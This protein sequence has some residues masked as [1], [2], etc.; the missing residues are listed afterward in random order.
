MKIGEKIAE[1]RREKGVTQAELA[2]QLHF[3][4]QAV[5]NWERGVTEPDAHTLPVLA[6]YFG[7]TTDELLG[8]PPVRDAPPARS[9]APAPKKYAAPPQKHR[10]EVRETVRATKALHIL[11]WVYAGLTA[12]DLLLSFSKNAAVVLLGGICGIAAAAANL[13]VSI[14]FLC[15]KQP[16]D[17]YTLRTVF[18]VCWIAGEICTFAYLLTRG[19]ASLAFGFAAVLLPFAACVLMPFAFR[20]EDSGAR[21]KYFILLAV[22]FALALASA[23][24][25]VLSPGLDF[26]LSIFADAA[27]IASLFLLDRAL[28][29]RTVESYY[30]TAQ[31]SVFS[32]GRAAAPQRQVSDEQLAL[33]QALREQISASNAAHTREVREQTAV[34]AKPLSAAPK[35]HAAAPAAREITC[36][37]PAFSRGVLPA[38]FFTEIWLLILIVVFLSFIPLA[39]NYVLIP[40]AF[41]GFP[42]IFGILFFLSKAG[43]KKV[44]HALAGGLWTAL[45]LLSVYIFVWELFFILPSHTAVRI[46]LHGGCF[47]IF[48]ALV[49][50]LPPDKDRSRTGHRFVQIVL[51]AA[52]AALT[53]LCLWLALRGWYPEQDGA[54]AALLNN[55]GF[56]LLLLLLHLIKA[57]RT[58]RTTVLYGGANSSKAGTASPKQ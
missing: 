55:Y 15:A 40:L 12:A 24:A 56:M 10:V 28:C 13:A 37:V 21:R 51:F 14:L 35:A 43:R 16:S 34:P 31:T 19:A 50:A 27:S 23:P 7:I 3:T 47:I 46:A 57:D 48:T 36:D 54:L 33:A 18:F 5:S 42:A 32:E 22:S 52:A 29:D 38:A 8:A 17:R 26:Y 9:A 2:D 6:A 30:Y 49:F 58:V 39:I 53:A 41:A 45:M 25:A 11:L 44:P 1:L 20:T 4:R